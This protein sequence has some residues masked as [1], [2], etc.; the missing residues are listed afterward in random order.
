MNEDKMRDLLYEYHNPCYFCKN[1][2]VH[3]SPWTCIEALVCVVNY[4]EIEFCTYLGT[5]EK[6]DRV[7]ADTE[8]SLLDLLKE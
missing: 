3:K 2:K 4:P 7:D 1:A 5:C 6:F 8:T